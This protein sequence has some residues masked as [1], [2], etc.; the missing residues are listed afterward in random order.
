MAVSAETASICTH[1]TVLALATSV[2]G[3]TDA[4]RH[5]PCKGCQNFEQDNGDVQRETTE[6][7]QPKRSRRDADDATA[8][9]DHCPSSMVG[10]VT[11]SSQPAA[12]LQTL[13]IGIKSLDHKQ[14]RDMEDPVAMEMY[15]AMV[16]NSQEWS[17]VQ[18]DEVFMEALSNCKRQLQGKTKNA[19]GEAGAT[20]VSDINT[21]THLGAWTIV[22]NM[23]MYDITKVAVHRHLLYESGA[24]E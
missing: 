19:Q 23:V 14:V 13:F 24:A 22:V 11:T 3:E 10:E 2:D 16:E 5:D 21:D 9:P 18:E 17:M 1:P 20:L 8:R 12:D 6:Q 15:T 7:R 4:R